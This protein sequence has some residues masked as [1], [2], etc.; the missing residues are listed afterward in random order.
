MKPSDARGSCSK[1]RVER[2]DLRIRP[3]NIRA[4]AT[5]EPARRGGC[6]RVGWVT[7]LAA[8]TQRGDINEKVL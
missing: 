8:S 3:G 7:P 5:A 1:Q 4:V 2:I 6:C